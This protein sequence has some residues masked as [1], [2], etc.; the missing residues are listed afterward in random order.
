MPMRPM[1]CGIRS[2]PCAHAHTERTRVQARQP[3]RTAGH[4]D[5]TDRSDEEE[6]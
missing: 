1:P 5:R 3:P 4:Y 6:S 2:M